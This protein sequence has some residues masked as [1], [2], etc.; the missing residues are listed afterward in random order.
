MVIMITLLYVPP[1]IIQVVQGGTMEVHYRGYIVLGSEILNN[2][3]VFGF[4]FI[5]IVCLTI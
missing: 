5:N 3:N 2:P 4:H 1:G